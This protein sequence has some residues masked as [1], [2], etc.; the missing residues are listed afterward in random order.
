MVT[1]MM[2]RASSIPRHADFHS[3]LWNSLF[4]AE[5]AAG[6]RNCSFFATFVS[7]LRFFPTRF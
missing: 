6:H 3:A 1:L 7:H 4:A 2:I 5:C